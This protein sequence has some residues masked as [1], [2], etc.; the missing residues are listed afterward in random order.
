MALS[1]QRTLPDLSKLES[2]DGTNYKCWSQK[3]LIFFEQLNINYV[4]FFDLTEE[5]NTSE[6][7]VASADG[8]NKPKTIDEKMKKKFEKVNKSVRGIY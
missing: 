3:L 2:L 5:N 7:I 1:I 8:T 4:L 6:T